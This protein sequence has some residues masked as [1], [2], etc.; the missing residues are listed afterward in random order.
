MPGI[1]LTKATL[2]EQIGYIAR[3]IN[4][5]LAQAAAMQDDYLAGKT[6]QNLVDEFGYTLTEADRIKG[7]FTDLKKLHEVYTG[8]DDVTPAQD[9]RAF[10]KHL[11]GTGQ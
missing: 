10:A 8:T 11:F 4:I 1:Q 9:F 7:A 3:T 6:S 2:D 5:V